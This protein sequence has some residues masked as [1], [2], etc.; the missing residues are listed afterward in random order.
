M[1]K[2]IGRTTATTTPRSDWNQIDETKVDFIKN[3]PTNIAFISE[4][5]NENITDVE[6]GSITVDSALSTT[7]TN[8]VQNKVI[9][10]ELNSLSKEIADKADK[11]YIIGVFEEL[12]ALI[13]SGNT[14]GA[15]AVLDA[16]ILDMAILA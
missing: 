9:A 13:E 2:I 14:A 7:S 1:S 8:P 6:S 3:K 4:E 16:A 5:D 11:A 15:I 12:K 10:Q